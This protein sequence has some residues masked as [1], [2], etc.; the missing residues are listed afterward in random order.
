MPG[1]HP[2]ARST[3][4]L[5]CHRTAMLRCLEGLERAKRWHGA[6]I[7]QRACLRWA[8]PA[9]ACCFKRRGDGNVQRRWSVLVNGSGECSSRD[10]P[11]WHVPKEETGGGSAWAAGFLF[12]LLGGGESYA[13][14]RTCDARAVLRSADLLSVR[15]IA[16]AVGAVGLEGGGGAGLRIYELRSRG[17]Y[18]LSQR[19]GYRA[20]A[21]GRARRPC[22]RSPWVTTP[23]CV[24]RRSRR[25]WPGPLPAPRH[26]WASQPRRY[27]RR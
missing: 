24:C 10:E 8:G 12:G 3:T 20:L 21:I 17:C 9:V 1:D 14:P 7:Q 15:A 19:I 27:R 2:L 25:S 26:S 23:R 4:Y 18:E 6:F 22:A 11:V 16:P 13:D 5:G